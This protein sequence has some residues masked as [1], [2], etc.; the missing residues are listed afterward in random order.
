MKV[1]KK[2]LLNQVSQRVESDQFL[3]T[4]AINDL[5]KNKSLN[6]GNTDN[7]RSITNMKTMGKLKLFF[8]LNFEIVKITIIAQIFQSFLS[9][10]FK[11]NAEI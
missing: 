8:D 6:S 4:D 7:K 1:L 9:E 3:M 11:K 5:A 2:K 10:F